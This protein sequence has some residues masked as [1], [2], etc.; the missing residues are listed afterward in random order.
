MVQIC[1]ANA[2]YTHKHV[3]ELC[4]DELDFVWYSTVGRGTTPTGGV[5]LAPFV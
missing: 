3:P 5:H 4:R 1:E 2:G